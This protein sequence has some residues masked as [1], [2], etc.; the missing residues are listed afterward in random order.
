M[1]VHLSTEKIKNYER[2]RI[3]F[4]LFLAH[5]KG[6]NLAGYFD[7]NKLSEDFFCVVLNKTYNLNLVNINKTGKL[8][9]K[10][11]DL[12]DN[13]SGTTYQITSENSKKKVKKN[14]D[15]YADDKRY[16]DYPHLKFLIL[17]RTRP[18]KLED[19]KRTS[20]FE[21]DPATDVICMKELL[22]AIELL[23]VDVVAEILE[24]LKQEMPLWEIMTEQSVDNEI[25]RI[26]EDIVKK[27]HNA[28]PSNELDHLETGEKIK[29][30]FSSEEDQQYII[31]E[32]QRC[33]TRFKSIESI[34]GKYG[35]DYEVILQSAMS[36][37]YNKLKQGKTNTNRDI[38]NLLIEGIEIAAPATENQAARRLAIKSLIMF[39]F[40]D[41][42]IFEKTP[43]E[44]ERLLV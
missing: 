15:G 4:D 36:D 38:F 22:L 28:T 40:E 12:I 10:A 19:L 8:N 34:I 16:T 18:Q 17:D 13:T 35:S 20:V 30:N 5:L 2:V 6:E 26:V 14:L 21:F 25:I 24:Y 3:I 42:T 33:L 39:H 11:I 9:F 23:E 27:S 29:L 43:K 32:Y 7:V 31:D 1:T 41:C 44:R 37:M